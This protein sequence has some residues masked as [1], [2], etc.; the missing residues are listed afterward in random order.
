MGRTSRRAGYRR[1]RRRHFPLSAQFTNKIIKGGQ[2]YERNTT[3]D[4]KVGSTWRTLYKEYQRNGL[5]DFYR[6]ESV[7]PEQ[8]AAGLR[9]GALVSDRRLA[10]YLDEIGL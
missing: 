2:A 7:S 1:R 5:T 10:D 8:I 6:K 3:H 4:A 9:T